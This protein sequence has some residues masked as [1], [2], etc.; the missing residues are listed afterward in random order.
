MGDKNLKAIAVYGTK[1]LHIAR[2]DRL[3]ELCR[4]IHSRM[5]PLKNSREGATRIITVLSRGGYYGNLSEKYLETPPEFQQAIDAAAKAFKESER[6]VDCYNCGI[7]C[8]HAFRRPDGGYSFVKCQSWVAFMINSKIPDYEFAMACYYLCDQYGMDSNS[9]ANYIAFAIDLYE[10]GILTRED[11]D[12]MHL[13]WKNRELV[14]ALI[15]KIAMREGI[16]DLLANGVYKA[17]RLIGRGAEEYA[18]HAKRSEII[19]VSDSWHSPL[20]ALVLSISDKGDSTRNASA[21]SIRMATFSKDEKEAYIQSEYNQYPKE[22]E[23]YLLDA[24][25]RTGDIPEGALQL[26]VYDEEMYCITD[27]IGIC[28]FLS[29]RVSFPPIHKR[30]LIAEL[31]ACATGM[32]IDEKGLTRIAR[33]VINLVR[34][35]N[36]KLGLTRADDSPPKMF[37]KRTSTPTVRGIGKVFP[38]KLRRQIDRFYELRGWN[39]DGVPTRKTLEEL[40]LDFISQDFEEK[41]IYE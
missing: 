29:G 18:H 8:K 6:Q 31:I 22:H 32:D 15:E 5:G 1:D 3:N 24:F 37:L 36:I 33:R 41:N 17:A 13:E 19:P 27:S 16:G 10:R 39:S 26:T 30:A 21:F 23:K 11:T 25:D 14:L 28:D 2:P 12:G 7:K 40:D 34:A 4:L 38:D 9:V 35:C 20:G